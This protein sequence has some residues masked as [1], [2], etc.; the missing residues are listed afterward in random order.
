[1]PPPHAQHNSKLMVSVYRKIVF[2][3]AVTSTLNLWPSKP[4]QRFPLTWWIY[5]ASFIEIRPLSTAGVNGRTTDRRTD[6]PKTQCC[7]PTIF[8]GGISWSWRFLCW[9]DVTVVA[10]LASLSISIKLFGLCRPALCVAQL[11]FFMFYV[12][13][14]VR[15]VLITICRLSSF[16][17]LFSYITLF[18]HF[19]A[20]K[21]GLSLIHI[22]RCRRR[23]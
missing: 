5:V 20:N 6:H 22:W 19:C 18:T 16:L 17:F 2:G 12:L 1:M 7:R 21:R 10:S 11:V 8:G 13:Y 3:L 23:G 4:F 9:I 14:S 15:C